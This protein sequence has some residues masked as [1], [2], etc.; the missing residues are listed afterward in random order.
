MK[1]ID[2]R[3]RPP[4][5]EFKQ[6]HKELEAYIA[7]HYPIRA[8]QFPGWQSQSLEECV[9]EMEELDYV[10]VVAGRHIPATKIANEHVKKLADQYPARFV[11]VGGADPSPSNRRA[12]QDE[13]ERIANVLKFKGVAIEPGFLD[14]PMLANDRRLY[15]IWAQCNDLGLFV[16]LQIGPYAGP[17]AAFSSPLQVEQIAIDF[18]KLQIVLHH[19]AYPYFE[20]ALAMM[21]RFKNIWC[22]P[23]TYVR[24]HAWEHYMFMANGPRWTD[25]ILYGAA[26]PYGIGLRASLEWHQKNWK[27]DPAAAERYFYKNACELLGIKPS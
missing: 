1:V 5:P 2:M 4:T 15:P 10:G 11:A 3:M 20:D 7:A 25:R 24:G 13:I 9:N 27:L 22:S 6:Q 26:T 18:P 8:K 19:G 23:D 21:T 14:P 17:T 16:G 12:A